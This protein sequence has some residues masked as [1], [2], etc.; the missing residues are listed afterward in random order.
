[1]K[2]IAL[3]VLKS[4]GPDYHAGHV[5]ALRDSFR[6]YSDRQLVCFSDVPVPVTRIPL[7]ENWPGWW[8]K[9]EMFQ[10]PESPEHFGFSFLYFDL[11]TVFV[12]D[13]EPL[14]RT[15]PGFTMLQRVRHPHDVGSGIM[16]WIGDYRRV[17]GR[18]SESPSAFIREYRTTPKWGDQGFIRDTIGREKIDTFPLSLAASYKGHCT[19]FGAKAFSIP[20]PDCR[21]VYFHGKPRPWQVPPVFKCR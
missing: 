19:N 13:P 5:E 18:F 10:P 8:S 14:W 21:V 11:D 3:C 15:T 6:R 16:S 17:Y 9:L 12:D 2:K 4:G 1:M 7:R 20:D